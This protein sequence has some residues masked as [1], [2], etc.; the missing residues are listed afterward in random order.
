MIIGETMEMNE[1][2]TDW[3][4]SVGH[5]DEHD[6]SGK[7]FLP[8][9]D[10]NVDNSRVTLHKL[11]NKVL[12]KH[13]EFYMCREEDLD[14][15]PLI[16]S[17]SSETLLVMKTSIALDEQN[18]W[19]NPFIDE[20]SFNSWIQDCKSLE[21]LGGLVGFSGALL[22]KLFNDMARCN[23][24][25]V[26][27]LLNNVRKE[28]TR[29]LLDLLGITYTGGGEFT[30]TMKDS[31]MFVLKEEDDGLDE[32]EYGPIFLGDPVVDPVSFHESPS[33]SLFVVCKRMR[34]SVRRFAATNGTIRAGYFNE[35]VIENF[36]ENGEAV[37][38]MILPNGATMYP[39]LICGET[40][41]RMLPP[42]YFRIE[43]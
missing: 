10:A 32:E 38:G 20:E 19:L 22:F 28:S 29:E 18:S 33:S 15:I 42:R 21:N 2:F 16:M 37:D 1:T 13:T 7:I 5:P 35:L 43:D 23:S 40:R 24:T 14:L 9:D 12:V 39:L 3:M 6:H 11:A 26:Q 4:L 41:R 25:M 30:S 34:L 31:C 27:L 8:I 36:D 17:I